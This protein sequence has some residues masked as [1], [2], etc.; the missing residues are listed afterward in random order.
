MDWMENCTLCP[1]MCGAD[2]R[3]SAGFCGM[4]ASI[5]AARA[6]PHLWEEPPISGERGTGAV[7]FSGCTL[8]CVYCQNADISARGFGRD[9]TPGQLG[10]ILLR[11]Q[12]E[13]VQSLSLISPTPFVPLIAEALEGVRGRLT[14]PVVY[15]T[16]GYE[17]VSTLRMLDGLVD[18]YLPDLKVR[19]AQL[20]ARYSAAPDYFEAASAAVREMARQ[21]GKPQFSP[22]GILLRGTLVRHLVLPGAHRDSIAVLEWLA[23]TFAPGQIL[24]SLMS[25]YTP[26]FVRG[27]F[28]ELRR[29]V[30]S[31]EYRRVLE[32]AQQLGFAGYCQGRSSAD[33]QY[34]PSFDLTGIR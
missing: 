8:R 2:R 22:G 5:R 17:R 28:P 6:A 9:I 3:K 15:N 24:L 12:G 18:V 33:A 32:R 34:T 29:R 21:T 1:R 16:G 14:V 7:F 20:G 11:L 13:G 31:Y 30:T 25:Q 10:E 4:G 26:D 23:Q 27:D 19:S